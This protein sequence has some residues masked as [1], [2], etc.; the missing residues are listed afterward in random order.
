[1]FATAFCDGC[2]SSFRYNSENYDPE[3]SSFGDE[4]EVLVFCQACSY[5]DVPYPQE[6]YPDAAEVAQILEAHAWEL[7]E[8]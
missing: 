4:D 6:D 5:E 8:L 2:Q 3:F 7:S 1:M